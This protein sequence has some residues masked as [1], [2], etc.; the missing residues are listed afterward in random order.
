KLRIENILFG[1]IEQA[2]ISDNGNT[3]NKNAS[4]G[5]W[6]CDRLKFLE[7]RDKFIDMLFKK[8]TDNNQDSRN[9]VTKFFINYIIDDSVKLNSLRKRALHSRFKAGDEVVYNHVTALIS[10]T[11]NSEWAQE[12]E[13]D[14]DSFKSV[15]N[16]ETGEIP[17]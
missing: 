13:A 6:V 15:N 17:F 3:N 8:L 4:I 14:I 12:F 9:Y 10:L 5:T 1:F 2:M 7:K 16:A 11:S